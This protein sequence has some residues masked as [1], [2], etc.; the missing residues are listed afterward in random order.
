M[1][2]VDSL[3]YALDRIL[4]AIVMILVLALSFIVILG[5]TTRLMGMPLSW[6]DELAGIGLAWLTFYGSAL[7]AGRG[8]H[9]ASPSI[10]AIIPLKWRL[11][12]TMLS[13]ICTIAFFVLLGWTGMYVV[14]ILAGSNLVSLP[15]VSQQLTQSAVPVGAALFILAEILRLPELLKTTVAGNSS[16]ESD[17][18]DDIF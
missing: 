17:A 6:T 9:I 11:A 15:A 2:T 13:E 10:L 7:A 5:F 14:E 3:R 1:N 18:E 12:V 16:A 8:A 4:A